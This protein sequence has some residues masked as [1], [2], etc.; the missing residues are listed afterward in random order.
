[1]EE[2]INDDFDVPQWYIAL[3]GEKIIAIDTL[4][5]VTDHIINKE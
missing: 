4:Y 5:R 2:S 1:M 3:D